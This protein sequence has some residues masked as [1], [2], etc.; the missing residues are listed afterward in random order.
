MLEIQPASKSSTGTYSG[1]GGRREGQGQPRPEPAEIRILLVEDTP[2][3]AVLM[4][5]LLEKPRSN[6]FHIE[7]VEDL[8]QGLERLSKGG[9][10]AVLLDLNLPDSRGLETFEKVQNQH[11]TVPVLILTALQDES[12][13]DQA[14]RMGAQD[15]LVKGH[16]DSSLLVRAIRYSIE[17]KRSENA[18]RISE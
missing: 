7:T 5:A 15:Y 6:A 18:L 12:L 3:D 11:P 13:A 10:D 8:A 1:P 14:I 4:G 2:E 17:R 16:V 9:I